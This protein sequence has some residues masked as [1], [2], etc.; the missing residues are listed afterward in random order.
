MNIK[1]LDV[2][3]LGKVMMMSEFEHFSYKEQENILESI[4]VQFVAEGINRFHSTLIAELKGSYVQQSQRYVEMNKENIYIPQGFDSIPSYFKSMGDAL[5]NRA[6]ILYEKM[7]VLK[8]EVKGRPKLSDFKYGIP[9]EDARY[10]LPL[11]V[12]TNMQISLNGLQL[13][14]YFRDIQAIYPVTFN[15]ITEN[16]IKDLPGQILDFI[17]CFGRNFG[18]EQITQDAKAHSFKVET[19]KTAYN[20]IMDNSIVYAE[21]L[22][23]MSPS[24][25]KSVARGALTSTSKG[26]P[27]EIADKKNDEQLIGVVNRV[28][29]YGHTSIAEQAVASYD[30]IMSLVT[31]HQLIRHRLPENIRQSFYD[32]AL[33][34]ND[35]IVPPTIRNSEFFMEYVQ[36]VNEFREFRETACIEGV[37]LLK[38]FAF[39][40]LIN[41]DQIRVVT[42]TNARIDVEI[43]K[44]RTCK[45]AQWEIQALYESKINNL[46]GLAPTLYIDAI[47]PCVYGVC[48]EGKLS[49]GKLEDVRKYYLRK[50]KTV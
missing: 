29:G 31:Y 35:I 12:T 6:F 10:L 50:I 32:V 3:N 5:I 26:S 11:S 28:M 27:T 7:T 38:E 25:I 47:P 1:N 48:K 20:A 9:Y 46:F 41:C 24:L 40:F 15:E 33:L 13:F 8:T 49:C 43:A 18:I 30:M 42:K 44:E 39:N 14:E 16:L 37:E 45:T 2:L 21:K 17:D 4:E 19:E 34:A 23:P 36:L 22:T